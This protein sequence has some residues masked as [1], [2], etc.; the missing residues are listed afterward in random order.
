MGCLSKKLKYL[1]IDIIKILN[2]IVHFRLNFY[3]DFF[4]FLKCINTIF[5]NFFNF[6]LNFAFKKNYE[7]KVMNFFCQKCLLELCSLRG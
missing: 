3:I 2:L 5:C 6:K 1:E 7:G 4:H